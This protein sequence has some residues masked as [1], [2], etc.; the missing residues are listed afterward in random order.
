MLLK[1][2]L[3]KDLNAAG[4]AAVVVRK[5]EIVLDIEP[6]EKRVRGNAV[7]YRFLSETK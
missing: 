4:A 6:K 1:C 3:N 2:S 7:A 5:K